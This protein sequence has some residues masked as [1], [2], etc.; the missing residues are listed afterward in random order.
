VTSTRERL[1][2]AVLFSV[3]VGV[4]VALGTVTVTGDPASPYVAGSG[5]VAATVLFAFVYLAARTGSTDD[6]RTAN[7]SK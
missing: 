7:E 1:G 4:G 6:D 3:P 5:V 2:W